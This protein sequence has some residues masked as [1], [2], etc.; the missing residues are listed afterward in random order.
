V[1][2][3]HRGLT[4]LP[5]YPPS[6]IDQEPEWSPPRQRAGRADP[7]CRRARRPLRPVLWHPSPGRSPP[8][9]SGRL[10]RPPPAEFII[11]LQI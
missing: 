4:S 3:G 2:T 7:L 1:T 10:R 5:P 6:W 8:R 11:S 9:A